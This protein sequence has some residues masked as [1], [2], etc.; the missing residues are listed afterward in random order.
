MRR[1]IE[2]ADTVGSSFL[3]IQASVCA[4]DYTPG[5]MDDA[6]LTQRREMHNR[7]AANTATFHRLMTG[8][9]CAICGELYRR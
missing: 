7:I 8:F 9:G 3:S 6:A 1:A 2:A 4:P 5:S